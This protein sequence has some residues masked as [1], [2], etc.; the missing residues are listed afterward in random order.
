MLYCAFLRGIN[1]N[2][3]TLKMA[4]V[5]EAFRSAGTEQTSSVL[6]TGNIIFRTKEDIPRLCEVLETALNENFQTE[7][8]LFIKSTN[9]IRSMLDAVPYIPDP[10]WHIYIFIC[11]AGFEQVLSEEF[12]T[13]VSSGLSDE[14]AAVKGGYFYWRVR[15]GSTL[16]TPFSKILGNRRFKEKFTSRNIS[17]VEKVYKK[18]I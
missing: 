1:V 15:K 5:C 14:S 6:A 17:T 11:D 8:K 10:D 4:E 18:M 9:E 7:S 2:G 12:K 13:A 16:D 3:R